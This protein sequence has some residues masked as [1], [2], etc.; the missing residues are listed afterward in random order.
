MKKTPRRGMGDG[1][2]SSPLLTQ[3]PRPTPS[4]APA[5]Q[6]GAHTNDAQEAD[7]TEHSRPEVVWATRDPVPLPNNRPQGAGAGADTGNDHG[8]DDETGR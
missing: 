5:N 2:P 8:H 4:P 6:A 1:P 7:M 3:L